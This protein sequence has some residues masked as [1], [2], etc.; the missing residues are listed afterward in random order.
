MIKFFR[1]IRKSLLTTGPK[2]RSR[3]GKY[4]LY[5]TGEIVLVV[6]GIL[7]ALQINNWNEI[8]KL[9]QSERLLLSNLKEEFVFNKIEFEQTEVSLS[10]RINTLKALLELFGTNTESI[11]TKKL[12]SLLYGSFFSPY[13]DLSDGVYN[14][15]L[16]SG[17]IE[18]LSNPKL[19][20]L[21][22]LWGSKISNF[23]I[24]ENNMYQNL[25][26]NVVPRMEQ[27]I[28]FQNIEKYGKIKNVQDSKLLS[29]NRIILSDL[30][31]ENI[32]FNHMWELY[33]VLDMYP[34]LYELID[35]IILELDN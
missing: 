24:Q 20:S 4:L 1:K 6:I 15:V 23:K 12:D 26:R 34:P 11:Q 35:E 18:L 21:L 13:V 5:A 7:I 31:A 14:S 33:N 3:A 32:F 29:D 22:L 17:K 19:K 16:N 2:G 27:R 28:S 25:N 9:K 10:T 30:E 8:D